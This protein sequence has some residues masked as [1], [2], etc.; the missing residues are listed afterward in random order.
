MAWCLLAQG[1]AEQDIGV[2]ARA[3]QEQ[4][5]SHHFKVLVQ[6]SKLMAAD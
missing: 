4:L 1:S 3:S 5:A 2:N 6:R